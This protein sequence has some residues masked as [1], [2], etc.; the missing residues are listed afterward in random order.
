MPNGAFV[1]LS[2]G[3]RRSND[4]FYCAYNHHGRSHNASADNNDN[5]ACHDNH[6]QSADN[7]NQFRN[8]QEVYTD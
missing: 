4:Y 7:K 6:N 5:G 1:R 2:K 8:N 3:R